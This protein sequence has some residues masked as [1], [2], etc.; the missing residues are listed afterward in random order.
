[1]D[2]PCHGCE[3]VI[4]ALSL[5]KGSMIFGP[6]G[7][8]DLWKRSLRWSVATHAAMTHCPMVVEVERSGLTAILN[9]L[10][11]TSAT[12]D[13]KTLFELSSS[14]DMKHMLVTLAFNVAVVLRLKNALEKDI[15]PVLISPS[16]SRR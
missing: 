15:R 5:A 6:I 16:P 3:G 2:D 1:M 12:S 4:V 11:A 10:S 7:S 14:N 13:I 8:V 9:C